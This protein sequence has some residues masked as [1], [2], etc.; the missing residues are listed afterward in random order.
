MYLLHG[1]WITEG[2]EG[3]ER[4]SVVEIRKK[5]LIH[6]KEPLPMPCPHLAVHMSQ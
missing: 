1:Y 3:P 2:R 5:I 4:G 6:S